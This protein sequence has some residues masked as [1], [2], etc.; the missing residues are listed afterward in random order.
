M[1]LRT[2]LFTQISEI[3]A[4]DWNACAGSGN[5]F[6]SHEFLSALE[7]SGS[8]GRQTGWQPQHMVFYDSSDMVVAVVPLYIKT[9]S[10]GE[11]VFD[12]GWAEALERTGSSYYPKLQVASPF[13]PV[14][15]IRLL[16]RPDFS[17]SIQE[18]GGILKDACRMGKLSSIHIT[19]CT[20][21]EWVTLGQS[22]WL[23]RIGTQFHWE[24]S[25]YN[26]F[27]SFLESLTS[28]HRKVLR[29]ERRD[30]STSGL[31]F[32]TL[33]GSSILEY[34]WDAF[35]QFYLSTIDRKWGSAYL[36]RSFF[37]LLSER[38]KDKVVLMMAFEG[39]TP[40][41]GALNLVGEDTLFGRHWG[42]LGHW[43]FLHF[44]RCSYQA[45]DYAIL[46]NLRRVE[47]GAQG[48]HKIQRGYLP[49][50]TYSLHWIQNQNFS[51]AVEHF[52]TRERLVIRQDMDS[53]SQLSP[54]KKAQD[55]H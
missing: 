11:Y 51:K 33:T 9:H 18:I 48:A 21:T 22:G 10:Y 16:R 1:S 41:A 49:Q 52:L 38:L 28:R 43:P 37:S 2:R 36:S 12:Q 7:D 19:F 47:A 17:I 40:V 24:N 15:G 30:A 27:D 32:R 55:N 13:S 20:E 26:S 6:T 4:E 46:H 42:C 50:L 5:P 44:E 3:P 34:H 39:S 54:Y 8:T 45:I 14:S 31:V 53:L 29:R 23:Q 25:N 35:Y